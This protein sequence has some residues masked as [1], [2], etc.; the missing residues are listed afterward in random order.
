[1][2]LPMDNVLNQ[3]KSIGGFADD[4]GHIF[5]FSV[6]EAGTSCVV[7]E[8][9]STRHCWTPFDQPINST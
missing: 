3:K 8:C 4:G 7:I 9:T 2:A 1:M 5:S 6:S